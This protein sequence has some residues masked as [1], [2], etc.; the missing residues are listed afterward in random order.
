LVRLIAPAAL[1]A[2]L[3]LVVAIGLTAGL[4]G[5]LIALL[6]LRIL[7]TRLLARVVAL[8]VLR[9]LRILILLTHSRA[10]VFRRLSADVN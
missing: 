9:V 1:L 8:L 6:M 10:P 2:G 4:V 5:I 7:L 3:T